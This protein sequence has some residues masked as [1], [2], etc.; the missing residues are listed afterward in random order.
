MFTKK[1]KQIIAQM[2]YEDEGI[3]AKFTEVT[4]NTIEQWLEE[5]D[6]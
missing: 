2:F 6:N 3:L 5:K 1:Q 4:E